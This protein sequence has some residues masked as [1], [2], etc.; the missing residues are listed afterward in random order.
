MTI[1]G[2]RI[3]NGALLL[4]AVALTA[5][6]IGTSQ[7]VTTSEKLSREGNVLSVFR[8]EQVTT[9]TLIRL[10]VGKDALGPREL[11]LVRDDKS[12]DRADYFLGTRGGTR[13]DGAAVSE[14]LAALEYAA[15]LRT[16]EA[17]AV[18][19][20]AFGLHEPR[21][22]LR[23]EMG[24]VSYRLLVG[25]PA[26]TPQGA[27]YAELGGT[28]VTS[29][30][31]GIVSGE[32][33][34]KLDQDFQ[35]FA[36]K[37]LLPYSKSDLSQLRLSGEGGER[38]IVSDEVG[39]R[40]ESERGPRL[41]DAA[42]DRVLFQMARVSAERFADV[43]AVKQALAEGPRVRIEQVPKSGAAVVV[44]VGGACPSQGGG[45]PLV[46]ALRTSAP[47]LA[48][49]VP[50]T[51]MPSLT[52]SAREL[53]LRTPFSLRA[54]EVD[55]VTIVESTSAGPRRLEALRSGAGFEL[56]E[57]TKKRID[58]DAG[59]A[60]VKA[61]TAPL[62]T[63]YADESGPERAP[64]EGPPEARPR[65]PNPSALGL[66]PPK[67]T[68]T[69]RGL[70]EGSQEPVEQVV[71][72]SAP[73][74]KGRV[75]L[76]RA[77]D[78]AVLALGPSA[79]WAFGTDDTWARPRELIPADKDAIQRIEVERS[80][81]RQIIQRQEVGFRLVEPSGFELDGQRGSDWI[82]S[83][84][85]LRA[86]RW[87]RDEEDARPEPAMTA[88]G[89]RE[90]GSFRVRVVYSTP[91]GERSASFFVSN[92]TV[93]GYRA[94]WEGSEPGWF[95][96]NAEIERALTTLP[97]SRHSL[98]LDVDALERLLVEGPDATHTLERRA[99]E[100]SSVDGTLSRD[101]VA[102]LSRA[103][104]NLRPE[105]AV[106][107]GAARVLE[108]IASPELVLSGTTRKLGEP[109]KPFR[110]RFGRVTSY[111]Q[112]TVQYARADGVDAT[113]VAPRD[114]VERILD[115]L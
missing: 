10:G 3:V 91:E 23:L 22:E 38:V 20:Q 67:G 85:H 89:R 39:F 111:E 5:A 16:I 33:V 59:N 18:D 96:L 70:R 27:F 19:R 78:G 83:V 41:D 82:A 98:T 99:G 71:T 79:A 51:V 6:V 80:G 54:D 103:L 12:P 97:I 95:V 93:G 100:L 106:H 110:L 47:E 81:Q 77:D 53:V 74:D 48:G 113:F 60:L 63:L 105:A 107:V 102:E 108:G 45:E 26:P 66:S 112:R 25:G 29:P 2:A 87:L 68:V 37:L 57:P 17:S 69:L 64:G 31:V 55:H 109:S 76:R 28:G 36:G 35:T 94:R 14:L 61:L 32:L 92:R 15:W 73:D 101:A 40:L 84:A 42:V 21:L 44:E 13:A 8:P 90:A 86:E 56:V 62:G 30:G 72:F 115:L 104:S 88:G 46:A 49:C 114:A 24:S 52:A 4:G 50:A 58:L 1:L 75:W 11:R 65:E 7:S 34:Q 43:G 9:L